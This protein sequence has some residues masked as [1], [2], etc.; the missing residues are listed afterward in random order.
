VL[1]NSGGDQVREDHYL[2]LLREQR[3]YGILMTPVSE[4]NKKISEI[5]RQGTLV[6]FVDRQSGEL[7]CSV[8]VEDDVGGQ[9]A[10]AH[11]IALGHRRIAFVGGP[12]TTR[13]VTDRLSG[14]RAATRRQGLR[15]DAKLI[16][17]T[18][19]NVTAGR[20]AGHRITMMSK[21][22]RPTGGLLRQRPDRAGSAAEETRQRLEVPGDLAI[23]GYDDIEF[24]AAAA[25]SLTSVR[26]P[27]A[28]LGHAAAELLIEEVS[29]RKTH[30]HRQVVFRP[31]LVVLASTEGAPTPK[32]RDD[33]PVNCFRPSGPVPRPH[34][35]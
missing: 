3:S 5:R 21:A 30:E 20:Y 26:Q 2:G 22:T 33:R 12:L 29:A 23:V 17:T 6:V 4:K 27:R 32:R 34:R 14:A 11:L 35:L 31:E 18:G 24:A 9:L 19:L 28:Q 10:A 15:D 25:V 7:Q 13:Q 16:E 1:C 8:S